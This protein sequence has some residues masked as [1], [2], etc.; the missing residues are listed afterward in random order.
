MIAETGRFLTFCGGAAPIGY[1]LRARPARAR[2]AQ[3]SCAR[4]MPGVVL[5][6]RVGMHTSPAYAEDVYVG[7]LNGVADRRAP[8]QLCRAGR[9][10][11]RHDAVPQD[12]GARPP[13][14][15]L[16][17]LSNRFDE[18]DGQMWLD[19][20]FIPWER[21]FLVE[22]SPEP[23]ATLAD[24]GITSTAGSPRPSSR[25]ASRSPSPTRWG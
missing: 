16:A 17:P 1:R 11:R 8:R 7:A 25:S 13:T 10:A 24:S 19:D 4:P 14:R 9:R 23:V 5:S 22:P 20:V 6:G 3:A 2:G 21:V 18:L 12:R 15:S